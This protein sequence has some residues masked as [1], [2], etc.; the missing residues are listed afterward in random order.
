MAGH[1]YDGYLAAGRR[2][3]KAYEDQHTWLLASP[4]N[5]GVDIAGCADL[6]A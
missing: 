1:S 3:V 5:R 2:I 4:D 6:E